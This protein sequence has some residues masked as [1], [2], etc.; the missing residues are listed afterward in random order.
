MGLVFV[1]IFALLAFLAGCGLSV[2]VRVMKSSGLVG[3]TMFRPYQRFLGIAGVIVGAL[4]MLWTLVAS[5]FFCCSGRQ[6]YAV[7]FAAG[8]AMALLG[9]IFAVC[10]A[11]NRTGSTL[12]RHK[13]DQLLPKLM[14][15]LFLLS[16]VSIFLSGWSLWI[17]LERLWA[18]S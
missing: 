9:L 11:R 13:L 6:V 3:D 2:S 17:L 1:A 14:P 7:F 12:T 4:M 18:P 8:I 16:L 5:S 15:A 10:L